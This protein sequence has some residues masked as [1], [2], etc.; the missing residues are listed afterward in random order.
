[1]VN[2]ALVSVT[3]L[4]GMSFFAETGFAC[5]FDFVVD[6]W[7]GQAVLVGQIAAHTTEQVNGRSAFGVVVVPA[8]E[9]PSNPDGPK[10]RYRLFPAGIGP[11]C[12]PIYGLGD[13]QTESYPV[14]ALVTVVGH[15]I[16]EGRP[17]NL[18]LSFGFGL[19]VL[20]SSC[21]PS[22]VDTEYAQGSLE[23]P[24]CASRLFHAYKDIAQL[25]GASREQRKRI[26]ARLANSN[27]F[28]R[29]ESIVEKYLSDERDRQ[30]LLDLQYGSVIAVG[31]GELPRLYSA[32]QP[33][34]WRQYRIR[35]RRAEYCTAA[36]RAP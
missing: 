34:D 24:R 13:R 5:S 11:D 22:D 3:A 26:L 27:Y 28:T 35:I 1:M 4:F 29:F 19:E 12:A 20:P 36:R 2:R 33:E 21:S 18:G 10:E 30:E 7:E 15:P 17:G 6:E 16:T 25:P 31:C 14:G 9:Y 23:E 8:L 32:A